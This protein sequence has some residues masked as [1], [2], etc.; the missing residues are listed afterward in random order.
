MSKIR[1]YELAKEVKI[2]S[3]ALLD[4]VHDLGIDASNHMAGLDSSDVEQIKYAVKKRKA[5]K[6]V[7]EEIK[8]ADK[9]P[10]AK[11]TPAIAEDKAAADHSDSTPANKEIL[12]KS[13]AKPKV[14]V[15]KQI[16][17]DLVLVEI[18]GETKLMR[19]KKKG[20]LKATKK[21]ADNAAD[22]KNIAGTDEK[23][24]TKAQSKPKETA[25][26]LT[27]EHEQKKA[28]K[29]KPNRV[30]NAKKEITESGGKPIAHKKA[31][32]VKKSETKHVKE[33]NVAHVESDKKRSSKKKKAKSSE[34]A[35][36]AREL[37]AKSS[38]KKK[39]KRQKHKNKLTE[40]ATTPA[41]KL[42]M[43]KKIRKK[44][45]KKK[46]EK[47][48][49]TMIEPIQET[50][51]I[52]LPNRITVG[53][54]AGL[55]DKPANEVIL[56]LM[57][58]GVMAAINQYIDYE[59]M[60]LIADDF[61]IE[62]EQKVEEVD[63][64][65]LD[66]DFED[67]ERDL[68][69]RAPV[70]TVMGHV[71]HGKTS[72]LDAIRST[73]VT[74]GEAGG[75]TQHIGASEVVINDQKIVFLDT[76]GH[77]A[78]TTLRARG[79]QV[80]DIAILVVAADDGVMPQTVEAIDHARAADVP[81]IVAVNKIDK[82]NANPD[83]VMKELAEHGVMVEQWGGD[84]VCVLV[85]AK[86]NQNI[87]QLLEMILLVA[88]LRDLK[89]NP[90]RNAVG[91]VIEA[92][93]DKGK[94]AVATV[95]VQNGKLAVGDPFVCG[96][97]YGRV[98]AMYNSKGKRIKKVGP[99][100]AV[101]IIGINDVPVAGDKFFAIDSDKEAKQ[102]AEKRALE[103]KREEMERA[104]GHVSLEDIFS[105][106][107]AGK[108]KE[109]SLII[110]ADAHGS[111]EALKGSLLKLNNDNDE[112]K[113]KIQHANIGAI[114]ES[115]IL[116]ATASNTIVLGFN[117]RPSSSVIAIAKKENVEIKTYRIIY[118]LLNDVEA[119]IKGM[120]DPEF[121]E[122][123]LGE[124]EV[125][126]IF[127][128]PNVGTIAGGYVLS[129]KVLRNSKI[130]LLRAGVIVHEGELSSLK[131]FKD[132]VKE[133]ASGYECGLGIAGFNDLKEGDVIEAYQIIEKVR[134]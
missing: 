87:D 102:I 56:K 80:T 54:F 129:G 123:Q 23:K 63:T 55:I 104:G 1:I 85:S 13:K 26:E 34:T 21:T 5:N 60:E 84:T 67:D 79:A 32:P 117:V 62:V 95:L 99:S 36:D 93:L 77:E 105:Q 98:R 122:V 124:I 101:E 20:K 73:D 107:Q 116:L 76:P 12:K 96:T 118:E 120:L 46:K 68:K 28:S 59:T 44:R 100:T 53:E 43:Q 90:D 35:E 17:D 132:D 126:A 110:K 119:A 134:K 57:N 16:S 114:T 109:L 61:G 14:I 64:A 94:G 121:E 108:M 2:S 37:K 29:E 115:D 66:Y 74:A 33:A 9:E 41:K 4:I 69:H 112:V 8:D 103:I 49:E 51:A 75:I 3:K 71:D 25:T 92:N 58:L 72:L 42:T 88:E 78:F 111:L 70:V 130:R 131:R 22:V 86:Q 31:K 6:K 91:I 19:R 48:E 24:P 133:V 50:T 27:T 45:V 125:R 128:V 38:R 65:V 89:A 81:I 82:P 127:K 15:K 39:E 18:N 106:I 40:E 83:R 47:V 113:I 10:P 7:T 52:Q 30:K 97:T 11:Q